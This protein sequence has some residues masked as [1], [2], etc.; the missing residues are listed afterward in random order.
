MPAILTTL[1]PIIVQYGVPFAKQLWDMIQKERAGTAISLN[2]WDLLLLEANRTAKSQL[3]DA[4]LRNSVD[5][6]S[7]LVKKLQAFLSAKPAA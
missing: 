6:E 7:D 1:I 3:T 4:L 5:A 2:D